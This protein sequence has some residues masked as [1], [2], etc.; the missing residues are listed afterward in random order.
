MAAN[1]EDDEIEELLD[2]DTLTR[3]RAE[4][5]GAHWTVANT[6]RGREAVVFRRLTREEFKR[7]QSMLDDKAR[8]KGVGERVFRDVLVYPP[9]KS[10][11]FEQ[12]FNDCPAIDE[13]V[14]TLALE[15]A[16]GKAPEEAKKLVP[17]SAKPRAATPP[18]TPAA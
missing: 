16:R 17:S 5:P 4:H 11:A 15:I 9:P 2:E 6:C 13:Q 1:I 3:L 14:S 7:A 8:A 10:P 18:S 12:L